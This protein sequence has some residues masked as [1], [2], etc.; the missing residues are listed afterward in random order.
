MHLFRNYLYQHFILWS[1]FLQNMLLL[2]HVDVMLFFC[3]Q[4]CFIVPQ[5]NTPLQYMF[6]YCYVSLLNIKGRQRVIISL[7][8]NGFT[9]TCAI[10]QSVQWIVNCWK[11]LG[12]NHAGDET[13]RTGIERVS[14]SEQKCGRNVALTNLTHLVPIFI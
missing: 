5:R 10:A 14:F 12:S 8:S 4:L 6:C 3:F 11:V 7:I 1:C 2:F 9:L 13:P